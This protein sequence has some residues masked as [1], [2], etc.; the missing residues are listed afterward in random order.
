MS[1]E[2][3]RAIINRWYQT[4]DQALLAHGATPETIKAADVRHVKYLE[5]GREHLIGAYC[6]DDYLKH[7]H[8]ELFYRDVLI[9]R[10]SSFNGVYNFQMFVP[11]SEGVT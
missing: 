5:Q 3:M 10:L 6:P 9:A 4:M 1:I 8:E 7:V 2:H 11:Q